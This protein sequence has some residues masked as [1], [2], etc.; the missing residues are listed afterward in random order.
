VETVESLGNHA[1]L[2]AGLRD[3]ASFPHPTGAVE[4]IETHISSVVL[5]GDFA[6][7]V[8]KPVNLGFAD[9]TTLTLRHHF[10]EEEIRLNRRGAPDLYLEVV[11]I[12]GTRRH[13]RI[14]A[15][16]S[17]E[18]LEYAVRMRRFPSDARLDQ[19]A[20]SG[21]LTGDHIDR[22]AATIGA[23]H[24]RCDRAPPN[25]DYGTPAD[26][27]RWMVENLGALH[28]GVAPGPMRDRIERLRAW[29]TRELERRAAVVAARRADGHVRECHGDLHLGNLVLIGDAPVPFDCIDFNDRLRFIDVINDVAF[30]FMDLVEHDLPDLAWRFIDAYLQHTGDYQGLAVLRLYAVYRALVRAKIAQIRL[31]QPD[32]PATERPEDRAAVARYLSVASQLAETDG[33]RL[34]LTCGVAGAGKTTVAQ[35]LL[36]RLGAIRIRSDVE[37]KRLAGVDPKGHRLEAVGAGLYGP[38]ATRRT[39]ERLA[40]TARAILA[41]DL[42]AVVD[43]TFLRRDD[44]QAF[45]DL[46]S[47]AG[48]P[49]TVVLC[50]APPSV[51]RARIARRLEEQSDPSDATLEVLEHQLGAFE[52]LTA[53]EQVFTIKIDTDTEPDSLGHRVAEVADALRPGGRGEDL[54]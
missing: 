52:P 18:I 45:L 49:V 35:R 8:K 26:V 20:L 7:K 15:G 53:Q 14:G 24:A 47:E 28:E 25:S 16:R 3:P 13:P 51:L 6:Y 19:V 54:R 5:A 31:Q 10:C 23:F 37:R 34:I 9:F 43:A 39:Y 32:T 2:I 29:T 17:G 36:E 22:L 21:R 27:R 44:R 30:T 42:S 48:V 40:E 50:E 38:E 1:V 4:V 46:A 12:T 33:R 41:A 11:P